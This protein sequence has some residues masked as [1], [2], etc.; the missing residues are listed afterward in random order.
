MDS[1]DTR[2]K[3]IAKILNAPK[4]NYREVLNL[5]RGYI[6]AIQYNKVFAYLSIFI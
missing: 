4:G 3:Q 5:P 2:K 1:L 6:T